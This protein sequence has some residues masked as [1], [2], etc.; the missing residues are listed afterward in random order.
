[1][2]DMYTVLNTLTH[3]ENIFTDICLQINGPTSNSSRVAYKQKKDTKWTTDA[4]AQQSNQECEWREEKK[5]ENEK[6][7]RPW[8]YG[9]VF[10]INRK[11][12]T[13]ANIWDNLFYYQHIR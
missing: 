5:M 10:V 6:K 3:T 1:M 8:I 9:Y 13:N 7:H 12:C 4:R 11:T 2:L